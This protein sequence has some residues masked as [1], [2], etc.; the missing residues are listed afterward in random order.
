MSC[1]IPSP[2]RTSIKSQSLLN[3][4]NTTPIKKPISFRK[5]DAH[6]SKS[7]M[8]LETKHLLKSEFVWPPNSI[9]NVTLID[10]PLSY[11]ARTK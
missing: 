8:N 5:S 9:V 10:D 2:S 1:L 11:Q 7:R 4:H 6:L 3:A